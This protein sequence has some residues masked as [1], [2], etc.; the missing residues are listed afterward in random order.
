MS[1]DQPVLYLFMSSLTIFEF[2]FVNSKMLFSF[3]RYSAQLGKM[4]ELLF[5]QEDVII[6]LKCGPGQPITVAMHYAHVKE[7]AWILEM[8]MLV[9]RSFDKTVR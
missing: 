6:K 7:V 2:E 4:M 9:I 5:S 3:C 1:H 8:S